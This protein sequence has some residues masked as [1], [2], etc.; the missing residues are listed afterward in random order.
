MRILTD[1]IIQLQCEEGVWQVRNR[2]EEGQFCSC[3]GSDDLI[4]DNN[5]KKLRFNRL[6]V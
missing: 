1:F 5:D 6:K 3:T 4:C 2:C